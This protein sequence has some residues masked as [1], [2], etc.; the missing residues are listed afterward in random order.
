MATRPPHRPRLRELGLRIGT[1]PTGPLNAITDVAGVAVGQVTL[2][3]DEPYVTRTGVTA[4]LPHRHPEGLAWQHAVFAG[5]HRYNGFGEVA[6][7]HWIAETGLLASPIV[8][9]SAFSAGAAR[10]ALLALPF[11]QGVD[12]RWHQP[13]VAETY[14]GI[15]HDGLNAPVRREHVE[16]ALAKAC[17]GPVEEGGV[18]GGT[19]MMSFELKSGIGTSS[20]QVR[21]GGERYTV[22][23]L[24]QSNFGNRSH[25]TVDGVPVGRHLPY[26]VVDSPQRRDGAPAPDTQGSV[27]L[28][29]AT[30]APLLP[31]QLNRLAHRASIG[32]ARVGGMGNNRSGDFILAFST[33]NLLPFSQHGV[34]QGLRMLG[35]ED[36]NPLAPAAAEAAEEAIVNSLTCARTTSGVEGRTVHELPLERLQAIMRASARDGA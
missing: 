10:D 9:T 11:R 16:A 19:G 17:G 2:R 5:F 7:T 18:G 22:G 6:G 34:M 13:C 15:L 12:D 35:P 1:L 29:V 28:V 31:A 26:S 8:L 4:I 3:A 25:L 14:D 27:V 20:R 36:M 30:D 33:G 21:C 23:V 24:V 32:L